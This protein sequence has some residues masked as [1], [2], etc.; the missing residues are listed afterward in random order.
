MSAV[1]GSHLPHQVQVPG[2]SRELMDARIHLP[3]AP[4]SH[5]ETKAA[6]R[7]PPNGPLPNRDLSARGVW[8]QT[9]LESND[10][11]QRG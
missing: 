6:F 3:S 4:I 8:D 2:A 7:Q 5:D 9:R 10:A 1:M 11:G